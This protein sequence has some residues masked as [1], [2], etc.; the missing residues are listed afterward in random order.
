MLATIRTMQR[1]M[2]REW[3]ESERREIYASTQGVL[4]SALTWRRRIGHPVFRTA[5]EFSRV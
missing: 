2:H 1:S 4:G 5:G 3:F